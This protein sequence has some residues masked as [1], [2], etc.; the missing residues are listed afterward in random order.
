MPGMEKG[1]CFHANSLGSLGQV[2]GSS[3]LPIY[4]TNDN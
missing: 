4:K 3:A 1:G 2:S